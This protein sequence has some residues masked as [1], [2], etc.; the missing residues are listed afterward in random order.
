MSDQI[1][2]RL[3]EPDDFAAV[4][5]ITVRGYGHDGFITDED[6][7]VHELADGVGRAASAEVYV[8]VLDGRVVGSV[9]FCPPGSS[10]RELSSEGE[11][12]FRMLAVDPVAR[13][14]GVGRALVDRCFERCSQLGLTSLVICSMTTMSK[15]HRL[16]ATF[17]FA[18]D[19]SLDWEPAPGIILWAFR[20]SV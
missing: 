1:Q 6:E 10:L 11:G 15:A 5:D 3:A 14:L 17:G 13:G 12:E 20:A 2:V 19:P 8:A 18:R 4:G 9:T 16:Y 7:Y